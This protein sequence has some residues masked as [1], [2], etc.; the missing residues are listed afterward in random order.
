MNPHGYDV[1]DRLYKDFSLLYKVFSSAYKALFLLVWVFVFIVFNFKVYFRV[2][3]R[4]SK[5]GKSQDFPPKT[6]HLSTLHFIRVFYNSKYTK[7]LQTV[8]NTSVMKI[9]KGYY[10]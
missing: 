5:Y 9:L 7:A 2:F 1:N 6:A 10:S 4:C 3:W 8:N